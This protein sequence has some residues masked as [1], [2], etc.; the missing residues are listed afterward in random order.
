MSSGHAKHRG[1]NR[2]LPQ[3]GRPSCFS[4]TSLSGA[5]NLDRGQYSAPLRPRTLSS[6]LWTGSGAAGRQGGGV[7]SFSGG[8]P[9]PGVGT[10]VPQIIWSI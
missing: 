8:E 10:G 3:R 2:A 6:L 9:E 5:E 1:L 4:G 7:P